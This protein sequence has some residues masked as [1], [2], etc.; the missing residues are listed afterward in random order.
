MCSWS[1]NHLSSQDFEGLKCAT[2][3]LLSAS[4]SFED[5]NSQHPATEG[6]P[7]VC[8]PASPP[9]KLPLLCF[10]KAKER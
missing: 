7:A 5:V 8:S 9:Y 1:L 10:S 2:Y 4:Y 3:S 6:M